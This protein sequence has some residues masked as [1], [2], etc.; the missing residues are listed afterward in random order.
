M[1]EMNAWSVFLTTGAVLDYLRYTSIRNSKNDFLEEGNEANNRRT[2][3][4]G[5]EY[6]GAG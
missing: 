5:N 1:D 2:D 3:N 4:L 6:R